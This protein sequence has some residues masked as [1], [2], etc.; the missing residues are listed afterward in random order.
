MDIDSLC[1]R[2]FQYSFG[3]SID[4]FR[5]VAYVTIKVKV[6][7]FD[8]DE[9]KSM[10]RKLV[11]NTPLSNVDLDIIETDEIP[12]GILIMDSMETFSDDENPPEIIPFHESLREITLK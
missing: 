3:Q 7:P 11:R 8:K 2:V 10:F 12:E 9:F 5:I 1:L 4:L 6:F